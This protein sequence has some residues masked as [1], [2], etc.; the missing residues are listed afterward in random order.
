MTRL[1][2]VTVHLINFPSGTRAREAVCRNEDGTFSVFIDARLSQEGAI[3]AY[4]HAL[5]HILRGDF[6]RRGNATAIE[7]AAH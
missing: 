4:R 6:D 3:R 1:D 7:A 2:D 5:G